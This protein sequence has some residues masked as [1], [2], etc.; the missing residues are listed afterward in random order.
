MSA[1]EQLA[2]WVTGLRYADIDAPTV[3]YA[4][5]LLLDHLGESKAA[6]A[7]ELAVS[8]AKPGDTVLI[9]G[10]GH[11]PYQE[12]DGEKRPFADLEEARKALG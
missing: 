12:Q 5:E 7:I 4:K 8:L 6:Q 3:A 2:G 11:E 10:K 9:A 1:S